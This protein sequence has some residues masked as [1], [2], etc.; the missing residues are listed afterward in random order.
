[1]ILFTASGASPTCF[2][3]NRPLNAVGC[4]VGC[5]AVAR[6]AAGAVRRCLAGAAAVRLGA[7]VAMGA[8]A[9]LRCGAVLRVAGA[10]VA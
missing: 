2:H 1:M 4:A 10:G 6:R 8:A 9:A 7:G 5:G 3:S